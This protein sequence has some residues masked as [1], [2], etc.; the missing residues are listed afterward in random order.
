[1]PRGSRRLCFVTA[2]GAF[3]FSAAGSVEQVYVT[4]LS[5]S[6]PRCRCWGSKGETVDTQTADAE[7]GLL[8]RKIDAGEELPGQAELRR[9]KNRAPSPSITRPPAPWDNKIYKQSIP[10]S[11]YGYLTTRDGTQL[12][13][14]VHPPGIPSGLAGPAFSS[15]RRKKKSRSDADRIR[16]VRLREPRRL[17]KAASPRSPT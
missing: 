11:G 9:A 6:P 13:I 8:F 10:E 17:R 2:A 15:R 14:D 4:G 1:M 12:A 3:A 7:G 5:P 16:R